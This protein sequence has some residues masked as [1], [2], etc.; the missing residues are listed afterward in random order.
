MAAIPSTHEH[1]SSRFTF[2]M[3]AIG[4]SVGLGN[5]WRFP[6]T[7]GEGGGAAFV[8]V[9]LACIVLAAYPLLVAE[10]A[11]GRRAGLS[12]VESTA[13]IARDSGRSGAWAVVGWVGMV[14]IFLILTFYSVIAGW[15]I[16]Y[17]PKTF[18]GH[19]NGL[20]GEAI[21]AEFLRYVPGEA[22]FSPWP[23]AF[24]HTVFMALTTFIVARGLHGGIEKVVNVLM[25]AFFVMLLGIVAY[26][27]VVGDFLAALGFLFTPDFSKITPAV[28]QS[29]LGQAFF[30]VGVGG[31]LMITY[32]A[33]LNK[34]QNIPRSAG[35]VAGADTLVAIVAGLAIFPFVFAYA[36]EPSAGP[37]L[38]FVTLPNAFAQMPAGQIVGGVFFTL[39]FFA[40]LTSSISLLEVAV[41]WAEE[42]PPFNGRIPAAVGLGVL[43]WAIG[44]ASVLV[45]G[46]LD[47]ADNIT[48]K[49][50]LPLGG[51]L[52]AVLAGWIAE[53]SL[54]TKELAEGGDGSPRFFAAWRF[55]VRWVSP[56]GV[57]LILIFGSLEWLAPGAG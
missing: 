37:G 29:A 44:M 47:L 36:L 8:L 3:A 48:G 30:S 40:A 1:W 33:Y 43:A 57:G 18:A 50:M 13:Q 46:F 12:A 25:P 31:S 6:Y 10:Y 52:M 19:F 24:A 56:I 28:A 5:F 26:G 32:G 55:L 20:D 35:I 4:S 22:S 49:I 21:T 45:P 34:S 41:S 2:L 7:A 51:L 27:A 39:A 11:V 54:L 42:R 15:V 9:Y 17:I 14:A 23:V 16:A 38:F 53:K